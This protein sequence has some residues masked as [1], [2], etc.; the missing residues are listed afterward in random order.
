M[1]MDLEYKTVPSLSEYKIYV[2][3]VKTNGFS[4]YFA[5]F[6]AG[7]YLTEKK[8]P[9]SIILDAENSFPPVSL[10]GGY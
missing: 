5:V 9:S 1:T 3:L 2:Y 7:C 4:N 10:K 8:K 6:I